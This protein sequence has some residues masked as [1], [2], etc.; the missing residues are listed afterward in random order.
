MGPGAPSRRRGL[1][2]AD[3]AIWAGYVQN[4][5]P[6]DGVARPEAPPAPPPRGGAGGRGAPALPA[7]APVPAVQRMGPLI[8]GIQP[9]GVDNATWARFRTG[10][11]PAGRT[12]DL[13]GRTAQRAFFALQSFLGNAHAD[14]LRVVEVITGRG[15]GEG[16]GVIRREFPLWLNLGELRPW[17]WRRR[18]RTR[19][20]RGRC[21]CCCG[22]R[23]RGGCERPARLAPLQTQV[24]C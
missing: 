6:L 12:L 5:A 20:T 14:R 22:G 10:K 13:H 16:G 8:V 3:R 23:G 2:E 18:T 4:V 17:C 19:P 7:A 15:S 24:G 21:G 11:L 9:P 1:S